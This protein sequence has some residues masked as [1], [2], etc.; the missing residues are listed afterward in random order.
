ME[1]EG[2]RMKNYQAIQKM[3]PSQMAYT[4]YLM[5]KPFLGNLNEE[6]RKVVY[7]DIERWLMKDVPD[8]KKN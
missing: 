2:E 5:M 4:F 8:G 3:N 6:E 1:Q 7:D